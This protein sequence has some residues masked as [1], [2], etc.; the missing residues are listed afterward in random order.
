MR[1]NTVHRRYANMLRALKRMREKSRTRGGDSSGG[2]W[3]MPYGSPVSTPKQRTKWLLK[4][5]KLWRGKGPRADVAWEVTSM[6]Q[7]AGL[8]SRCT[9]IVDVVP[10]VSDTLDIMTETLATHPKSG[11]EAGREE[12][13]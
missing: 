1:N 4:N 13:R 7:K 12:R 3:V 10:W 8:Y 5:Q 2:R 11:G 6:M 9:A